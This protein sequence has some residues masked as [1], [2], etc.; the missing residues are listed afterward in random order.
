[1]KKTPTR[2]RWTRVIAVGAL[3]CAPGSQ[4]SLIAHYTFDNAA[5]RGEDT[6]GNSNTGAPGLGSDGNTYL[7]DTI[8]GISTTV[9]NTDELAATNSTGWAIPNS[10]T[11]SSTSFTVSTWMKRT[12]SINGYLFDQNSGRVI[13]ALTASNGSFYD[14]SSW[15]DFA[16]NNGSE[17]VDGNWHLATV[18][19]TPDGGGGSLATYYLD[20]ALYDTITSTNRVTLSTQG[21]NFKQRVGSDNG[22]GASMRAAL[23]DIRIYDHALSASDVAALVPEPS[24]ALLGSLGLIGGLMRRRRS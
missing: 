12:G 17:Y 14:G 5:A 7:T 2:N 15:Y 24:V 6:S 21:T 10:M 9:L 13:I 1:M 8:N 20:G 3:L 23:D 18:V 19:V 22:G 16:T 11:V 4:A